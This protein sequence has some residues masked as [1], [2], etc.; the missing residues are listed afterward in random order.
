M[1][2]WHVTS[3]DDIIITLEIDMIDKENECMWM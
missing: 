2:Q 3:N 1:D